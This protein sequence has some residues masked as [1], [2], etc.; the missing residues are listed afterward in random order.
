MLKRLRFFFF[1]FFISVFPEHTN[2]E[3][4][5]YSFIENFFA[6]TDK[7]SQ[8]SPLW[9]QVFF[10]FFFLSLQIS[11]LT[12]ILTCLAL[13]MQTATPFFASNV[14]VD[15]ENF[16]FIA[17]NLTLVLPKSLLY[18]LASIIYH[19]PLLLNEMP[20]KAFHSKVNT[21]QACKVLE[22]RIAKN[23]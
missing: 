22:R 23:H 6:Q 21:S 11:I 7:Y 3:I 17:Y 16:Y 1:H 19:F 13:I 14:E 2:S 4:T 5:S 20:F 8:Y 9:F 15:W 12:S 10:C 18:D